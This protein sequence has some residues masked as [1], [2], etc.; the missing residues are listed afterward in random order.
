MKKTD[1]IW[2][3]SEHCTKPN[4]PTAGIGS[5][6]FLAETVKKTTEIFILK[7]QNPGSEPFT[8]KRN[9][10]VEIVVPADLSQMGTT[11]YFDNPLGNTSTPRYDRTEVR[12]INETTT[13]AVELIVRSHPQSKVI[14]HNMGRYKNPRPEWTRSIYGQ[15]IDFLHRTTLSASLTD[16]VYPLNAFQAVYSRGITILRGPSNEGW[17]F[18]PPEQRTTFDVVTVTPHL[19]NKPITDF[20]NEDLAIVRAKLELTL[21]V[22]VMHGADVVVLGAFGCGGAKN[23]PEKVAAACKSVIEEFAGY[24][25]HIYFAIYANNTPSI[26]TLRIF[27]STLVGPDS[28]ELAIYQLNGSLAFQSEKAQKKLVKSYIAEAPW[29]LRDRTICISDKKP[30][31]FCP[32]AGLCKVTLSG[33]HGKECFHPPHCPHGPACCNCNPNHKQL[34]VHDIAVWNA[35][36]MAES[37][38]ISEAAW[39]RYH[40]PPKVLGD[41]FQLKP[42]FFPQLSLMEYSFLLNNADAEERKLI[43]GI[44]VDKVQLD[45][46]LPIGPAEKK[47]LVRWCRAAGFQR[48]YDTYNYKFNAEEFHK[49][50]DGVGPTL[51]LIQANSEH[52]TRV[53]GGYTGIP[54]QSSGPTPRDK[55]AGREFVFTLKNTNGFPPTAFPL[56]PNYKNSI[57]FDRTSGPIFGTSTIKIMGQSSIS[58]ITDDYLVS[59]KFNFTESQ[60]TTFKVLGYEVF[61]VLNDEDLVA[62]QNNMGVG[63]GVGGAA[64]KNVQPKP[65]TS[66]F[67]F[68]FPNNNNANANN[69]FFGVNM[70]GQNPNP[71][72][73]LPKPGSR[74]FS[75][76][77]LENSFTDTYFDIVD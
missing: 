14:C 1:S 72:A 49:R 65:S 10:K 5:P 38:R 40:A 74:S 62:Q 34:F 31:M 4:M 52:G 47:Y 30:K 41:K 28:V 55:D 73:S 39:A 8:Q 29:A 45:T 37:V 63:V 59:S 60:T 56:A 58:S 9:G 44:N 6:S 76:K 25:S 21:S 17:P 54:W 20:G 69:S 24:F 11:M 12:V 68:S 16:S 27:A 75:T 51:V 53:F 36:K 18:L 43:A 48:I 50:C 67:S 26:E 77:F 66:F 57:S 46:I 32:D 61:K 13:T 22:C 33:I 19:Y 70:S 2:D 23:P 15:E 3:P 35:L 7:S 64:Q 42:R 71:I